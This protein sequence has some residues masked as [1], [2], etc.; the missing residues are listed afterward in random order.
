MQNALRHACGCDFLVTAGNKLFNTLDIALASVLINLTVEQ[1]D[2]GGV[3]L[4]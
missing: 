2:D 4:D 1:K 3:G